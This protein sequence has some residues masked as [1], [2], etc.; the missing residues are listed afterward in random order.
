VGAIAVGLPAEGL[1]VNGKLIGGERGSEEPRTDVEPPPNQRRGVWLGG[2]PGT[3]RV[4]IGLDA[5]APAQPEN[6]PG[7]RGPGASASLAAGIRLM[8]GLSPELIAEVL[9]LPPGTAP[10][11]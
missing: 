3:V 10:A 8:P 4:F 9:G 1:G 11:R 5:G 6:L 2:V 7:S